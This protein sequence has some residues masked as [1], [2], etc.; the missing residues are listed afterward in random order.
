MRLI[1]VFQPEQLAFG[2]LDQIVPLE[3]FLRR[4]EV[5]LAE[6]LRAI[7]RPMQELRLALQPRGAPVGQLAVEIVAALID[8]IRRIRA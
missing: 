8:G 5:G 7:D 3:P 6:P 2:D 4:L 1:R